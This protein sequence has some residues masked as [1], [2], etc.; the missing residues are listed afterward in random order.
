M[1]Q[2]EQQVRDR[3]VSFENIDCYKDAASVLDAMYELF[4]LIPESKNKFWMRFDSFIPENYHEILAKENEK[5]I[6]Y[7]ICSNVFYISDLF[8]EYEFE[9]GI[10]LLDS[11]EYDCC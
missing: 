8:D 2:K 9:K 10:E 6:L 11:I 5:D 7:Q 3:Y 4:E 1:G